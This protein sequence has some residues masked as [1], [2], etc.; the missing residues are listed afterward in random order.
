M[1][2]EHYQPQAQDFSRMNQLYDNN[3]QLPGHASAQSPFL[4]PSQDDISLYSGSDTLLQ[5]LKIPIKTDAID[6]NPVTGLRKEDYPLVNF[7]THE[8]FKKWDSAA[9]AQGDQRGSLPFLEH[10]N[11]DPVTASEQR[12]IMK[13]FRAVWFGLRQ[14]GIAPISWGRAIPDARNAL[15]KE[16]SRLHPELALCDRYWKIEH[17]ARDRY[18]SWAST[19]LKEGDSS[20]TDPEEMKPRVKPQKRKAKMVESA[21]TCQHD[22]KRAKTADTNLEARD[23]EPPEISSSN[24]ESAD[25]PSSSLV[26]PLSPSPRPQTNNPPKTL[27]A[28]L[29]N[30]LK[31]AIIRLKEKKNDE[32]CDALPT[33][34]IAPANMLPTAAPIDTTLPTLSADDAIAPHADTLNA[35]SQGKPGPTSKNFRPATTKNGR[36]LCAHRW[37]KQLAPNGYSRDFKLYWDSLGKDRQEKYETDAKKLISDGIWTGSTVKVISKFSSS[38]LF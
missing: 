22:S 14:R 15:Y 34:S 13:T 20:S 1:S 35:D 37:L 5:P 28:P 6:C 4:V 32:P 30:P 21:D 7:W 11:G 24:T 2:D 26:V 25:P 8:D 27:F 10:T 12:A 31:D 38:T 19:H 36:N 16:V 29:R 23:S 3:H 18:P 33:P 17:I 9:D